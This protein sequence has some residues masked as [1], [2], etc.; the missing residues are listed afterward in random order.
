MN[1]VY[2]TVVTILLLIIAVMGYYIF[3]STT[4]TATADEQLVAKITK[5]VMDSCDCGSNKV[6]KN[7]PRSK[8]K[9]SAPQKPDTPPIKQEEKL[10][11]EKPDTDGSKKM[12][13][14][15]EDILF[16][17]NIEQNEAWYLPHLAIIEGEKFGKKV[18][19]NNHSGYNFVIS[20]SEVTDDYVGD[21]GVT[22]SGEYYISATFV[23]RHNPSDE[24]PTLYVKSSKDGW[25][26]RIMTL[27]QGYYVR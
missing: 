1:R 23:D 2:I 27:K 17:V 13:T 24:N 21:F 5:A 19:P 7:P 14:R 11:S 4:D 26:L 12:N 10:N 16:C 15:A 20:P 3:T 8:P 18:A 22:T 9:K 25:T 6:V